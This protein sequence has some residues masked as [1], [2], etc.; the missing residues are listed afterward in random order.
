[1]VDTAVI[2]FLRMRKLRHREL[3]LSKVKH[4]KGSQE[5]TCS[6]ILVLTVK[7]LGL[8]F[9]FRL[10]KPFLLEQTQSAWKQDVLLSLNAFFS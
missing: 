2:A 5:E 9:S 3:D 4:L 6:M 10:V 8:P 1:M 7:A